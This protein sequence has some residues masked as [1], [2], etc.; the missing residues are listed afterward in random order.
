MEV[1]RDHRSVEEVA[2]PELMP[3][4]GSTEDLQTRAVTRSF[5]DL[6]FLKWL[7]LMYGRTDI[8]RR[9]APASTERWYVR[10]SIKITI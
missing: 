2:V 9:S 10:E 4:N 3:T 1:D 8:M 5:N 7:F 6:N